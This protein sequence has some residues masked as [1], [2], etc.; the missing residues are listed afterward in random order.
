MVNRVDPA[1]NWSTGAS[2]DPTSLAAIDGLDLVEVVAE[3]TSFRLTVLV[4]PTGPQSAG[5]RTEPGLPRD[6]EADGLIE[7]LH[8]RRC[9]AGIA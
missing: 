4:P 1:L 6:A 7:P 8:T 9:A 3:R 2:P 5:Y